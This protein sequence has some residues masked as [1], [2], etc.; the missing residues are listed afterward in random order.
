M[1]VAHDHN[2]NVIAHRLAQLLCAE[3]TVSHRVSVLHVGYL[4]LRSR[5]LARQRVD[6]GL[7]HERVRDGKGAGGAKQG[8]EAKRKQQRKVSTRNIIIII[9]TTTTTTNNINNNNNRSPRSRRT[10]TSRQTWKGA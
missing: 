10:P 5:L 7:G 4:L 1:C 2:V 9:I 6:N 3:M 8:G